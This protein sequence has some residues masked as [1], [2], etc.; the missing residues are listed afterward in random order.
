[1]HECNILLNVKQNFDT[2]P[3]NY[4]VCNLTKKYICTHT[5]EKLQLHSRPG[6][7]IFSIRKNC[8][9][10]LQIFMHQINYVGA[11]FVCVCVCLSER[12][13]Y[14]F[15]CLSILYGMTTKLL[16]YLMMMQ[17]QF[18]PRCF[19][20]FTTFFYTFL[21]LPVSWSML[22]LDIY[23]GTNASAYEMS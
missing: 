10:E 8:Q 7:N 9:K 2:H 11:Y 22:Y 16:A 6:W 23:C 18:Y 5:S 4:S 12:V 13:L 1:M 15:L 17:P 20:F 19:F 3:I 14:L 21:L